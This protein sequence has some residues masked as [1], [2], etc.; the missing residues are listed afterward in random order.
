MPDTV[1]L[2]LPWAPANPVRLLRTC[3]ANGK[4]HNG[5]PWPLTVGALV[6][7][8]DWN[9]RAACG[10]GLHGLREGFGNF[11]LLSDSSDAVWMVVEAEASEIV[12][13]DDKVKAPRVRVALVGDRLHAV[14]FSQD[15]F[16]TRLRAQAM[17]GAQY[18]TGFSGHASATGFR[19]HASAT[20]DSG[21]ASATGFSGHA[22]ATGDS[23]HASATGVSGHA[24]AAGQHAIAC[25]LG[26]ESRVKADHATGAIVATW[27]DRARP[28]V[29]VGYVGEDGIEPGVWYEATK[30]GWER[31]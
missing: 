26:L 19:G 20:G 25:A 28:R 12:D 7:A 3:D 2:P 22:S 16:W 6:E 13:V 30:D 14:R 1:L 21:H 17:P 31:V 4:S 23:G 27:W 18:A 29:R 24:S 15:E 10:G 8:P 9:D 11:G 5:F